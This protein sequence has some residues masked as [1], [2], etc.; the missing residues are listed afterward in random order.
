[1]PINFD[2]FDLS[3]YANKYFVETGTF[4][5]EGAMKALS[6]GS[7]E[8][9]ITIEVNK[10]L[11]DRATD[12]FRLMI[13]TGLLQVVHDDSSRL[14]EY[15]SELDH[16]V[17]FFLDAHGNW[18][19][20]RK[21]EADTSAASETQQPQQQEQAPSSVQEGAAA[22]HRAD[23]AG[24]DSICPL[25][26]ELD[27]IKKHPLAG[28]HTI[29]IDDRRCMQP[30]WSHPTQSWWRGLSEEVVLAKLREINPD[31]SISFID[32]L[33]PGDIIAAVPP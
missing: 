2:W 22:E 8:K 9:V 7:F 4:H 3:P 15:I 21:R 25:L 17:T 29:L 10:E 33:V 24:D 30:G 16:P 11:V 6:S 32:G 23:A 5:G 28:R 31:F 18:S 1:M 19:Q 26:L 14:W 27:A 20:E 12:K 13:A